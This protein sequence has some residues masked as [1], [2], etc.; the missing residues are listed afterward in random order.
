MAPDPKKGDRIRASQ[1]EHSSG[2]DIQVFNQ[3]ANIIRALRCFFYIAAHLNCN[4][5]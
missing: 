5:K 3:G 4:K 1:R 2:K